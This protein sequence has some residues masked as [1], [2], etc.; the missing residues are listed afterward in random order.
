MKARYIV[1]VVITMASMGATAAFA[2]EYNAK[3]EPEQ[4]ITSKV[5]RAEVKAE[6]RSAIKAKTLPV[7][8]E[9]GPK[10]VIDT[11]SAQSRADVKTE[12]RKLNKAGKLP[13]PGEADK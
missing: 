3:T 6:V 4:L 5:P 10:D 8:G 2:D 1:S 13:V 7:V 12:V 11:S 9:A